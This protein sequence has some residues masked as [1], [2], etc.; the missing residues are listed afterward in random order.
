M[1]NHEREL[2]ATVMMQKVLIGALLKHVT[3]NEFFPEFAEEGARLI[4][5]ANTSIPPASELADALSFAFQ[6]LGSEIAP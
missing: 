5:N 2:T 1:N 3:Y 6:T 4:R